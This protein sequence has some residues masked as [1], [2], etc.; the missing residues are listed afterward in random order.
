M[1]RTMIFL[2]AFVMAGMTTYLFYEYTQGLRAEKTTAVATP[3]T[4]VLVAKEEIEKNAQITGEMVSL[5]EVPEKAV[6][7]GAVT[8][9]EEV[10]G[11]TATV[12]IK[13]GETILAHHIE[14]PEDSVYLAQRIKPGFRAV[15]VGAVAG[16]KSVANLIEPGDQVDLILKAEKKKAVVLLGDLNVLAVDRRME[17][18]STEHPYQAYA[19][20]TLEVTPDNALKI[21]DAKSKGELTFIL[22]SAVPSSKED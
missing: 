19:M 11:K 14:A 6:Q 1:K 18:S 5:A 12:T 8:S 16:A 22:R 7:P 2:L 20:V 15:T 4:T 3:M 10:A 13:Q 9:I 21:V 17:L